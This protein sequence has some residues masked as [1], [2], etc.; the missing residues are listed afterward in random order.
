MQNLSI[1][2]KNQAQSIILAL[3][4]GGTHWTQTAIYLL[5]PYI[6]IDLGLTYTQAG[7]ILTV[8]YVANFL[9]S[10]LSG[11]LV[12]LTGRHV[13]FQVISLFMGWIALLLISISTSIFFLFLSVVLIG[14]CISL[15]HPAA[16]TF[17]SLKYPKSR[18]FALS[19]HSIGASLGD[20]TVP[21]VGGFLLY[22]MTWNG[23]AA[24]LSIPLF[25]LMFIIYFYLDDSKS[26]PS[27][28]NAK[29][30]PKS[31]F[32]NLKVLLKNRQLIPLFIVA[33][34]RTLTQNGVLFTMPLYLVMNIGVSPAIIGASLFSMQLGGLFS[35]PIAGILS[36]K[37]GR[38]PVALSGLLLSFLL[39]PLLT[40]SE[41]SLFLIFLCGMIGF[42]IYSGRPVVQS[43]ALDIASEKTSGSVISLL[44]M[45]Q[46][47]FAAVF[48]LI[49]GIVADIYGL[50]IIFYILSAICMTATIIVFFI[51]NKTSE[52]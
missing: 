44:F 5:L 18:G 10:V 51:P 15:W 20:A 19:I 33:G 24:I 16:L 9:S 29:L 32:N 4:H 38:K 21:L 43:W 45:A 46:V 28:V 37:V 22:F 3:G 35:G 25:A 41:N 52:S 23:T 14:I 48:S 6:T 27:K 11:P 7:L 39:I 50:K 13:I 42:A 26:D 31:Y 36:D 30:S 1:L 17:L 34:V 8:F 40:I 12:D 47:G 2:M 49:G